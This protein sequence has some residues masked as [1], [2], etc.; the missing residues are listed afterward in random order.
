MRRSSVEGDAGYAEW[1]AEVAQGKFHHILL[2][3]IEQK[4]V[5]IADC[6][7]GVIERCVL[8]AEGHVQADPSKPDEVWIEQVSG[9]VEIRIEDAA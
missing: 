8:N 1:K 4:H 2:D 6:R 7:L 5:R 3:G 9:K